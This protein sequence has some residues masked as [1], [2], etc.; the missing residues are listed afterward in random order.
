MNTNNRARIQTN[1]ESIVNGMEFQELSDKFDNIIH[2]RDEDAIEASLY[3]IARILKRIFNIET[4][5][6][7]IDR[8][9]QSP[10]FGFNLFPTF[11]DIKDI[12]VKV[13]SN[14]T[15]DII[16]IWQNTDD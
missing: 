15:D 16:D 8:T 9:G 11:E 2:T 10:F 1:L 5:F 13:L 4:K 3:H 6:S 12:S 7:I 14:S